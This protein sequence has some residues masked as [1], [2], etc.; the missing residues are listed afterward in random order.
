[1]RRAIAPAD[2]LPHLLPATPSLLALGLLLGMVTGAVPARA[3]HEDGVIHED[4]AHEDGQGGPRGPGGGGHD[5][6]GENGGHE[7]GG[8][9][10]GPPDT[11]GEDGGS[12]GRGP[13]AN[14]PDQTGGGR[15]VWAR[16][17]IP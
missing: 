14:R 3:E 5:E 16:E 11:R 4:G 17:G 7:D 15:P 6:G 13:Q 9:R 12:D 10:D 8:G 2:R 1:M